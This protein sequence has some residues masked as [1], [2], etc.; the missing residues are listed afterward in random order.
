MNVFTIY[1]PYEKLESDLIK[2]HVLIDF[3]NVGN[4]NGGLII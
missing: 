1:Q 3:K 4:I 2:R